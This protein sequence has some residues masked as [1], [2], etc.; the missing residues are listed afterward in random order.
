MMLM[1]IQQEADPV[2][3]SASGDSESALQRLQ[4]RAAGSCASE[5]LGMVTLLLNPSALSQDLLLQLQALLYL[6]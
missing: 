4:E 3:C 5:L 6:H 2:R 1:L